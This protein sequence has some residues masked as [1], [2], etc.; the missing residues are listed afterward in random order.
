M[1]LCIYYISL[2]ITGRSCN[3]YVR[4]TRITKQITVKRREFNLETY[5]AFVELEDGKQICVVES[6]LDASGNQR[7]LLYAVSSLY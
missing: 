3:D 1:L 7:C 6:F 4:I 5:T 2:I